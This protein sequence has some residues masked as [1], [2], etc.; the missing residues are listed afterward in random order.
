LVW[1]L[2]L[3]RGAEQ[4]RQVDCA[5]IRAVAE[6]VV[7]RVPRAFIAQELLRLRGLRLRLRLR[8]RR[9][10]RLRR[11]ARGRN[12][13]GD[14][15]VCKGRLLCVAPRGDALRRTEGRVALRVERGGQRRQPRRAAPRRA[16]PR[17]LTADAA[18][19]MANT[20]ATQ[21][22]TRAR[23]QTPGR[24]TRRARRGLSTPR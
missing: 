2:L 20:S 8:R 10:R 15:R 13:A 19:L 21:R 23:D 6:L 1:L 18:A 9:R 12:R 11:R 7:E 22:R 4:L 16:A 17:R 14:K 3:L 24:A 5:Q